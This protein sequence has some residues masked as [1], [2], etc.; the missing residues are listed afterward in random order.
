MLTVAGAVLVIAGIAGCSSPASAL[1]DAT[2]QVTINGNRAGD[3]R[4]ITCVQT[5]WTQLI[6]T[7]DEK[8]GF[9]AAIGTGDEF[10][11]QSVELRDLDGFTGI[12]WED[13]IGE[14]TVEGTNGTYTISGTAAGGFADSGGDEATADFEIEVNC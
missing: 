9:T 2:A 1:G 11:V 4:P 8:S 5:S 6:N 13:R 7:T 10:V 3:S 14:A 12:Y